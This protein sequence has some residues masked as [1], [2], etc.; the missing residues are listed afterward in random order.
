MA[1]TIEELITQ[2]EVFGVF[3]WILPFLLL[4]AVIFGILTTTG[5][6]GGNRGTS[7]IIAGVVA[8]LSLRVGFVQAFFAELF[9]RFAVGLAVLIVVVLLAGLFWDDSSAKGWLIGLGSA[10]A[11]IGVVVMIFTFNTFG[12][13]DSFFWQ[14]NIGIIVIGVLLLVLIVALFVGAAPKKQ[15]KDLKLPVGPIRDILGK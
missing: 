4:F 10:G 3:D 11:V 8:L 7:M 15:A 9:P 12:W 1:F 14:D 6:L 13:F 5:I 2:W